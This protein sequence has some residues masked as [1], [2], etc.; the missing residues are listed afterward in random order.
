M[1]PQTIQ[2]VSDLPVPL[3]FYAWRMP[4]LADPQYPVAQIAADVLS[5]ERAAFAALGIRRAKRSVPASSSGSGGDRRR[6]AGHDRFG[7]RNAG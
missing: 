5:S 6:G 7:S 1:K 3:A 2:D 4:G